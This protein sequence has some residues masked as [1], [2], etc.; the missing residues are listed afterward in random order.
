MKYFEGGSHLAWYNNRHRNLIKL[1]VFRREF[2]FQLDIFASLFTNA[3]WC[4]WTDRKKIFHNFRKVKHLSGLHLQRNHFNFELA[5][6]TTS[7]NG[8]FVWKKQNNMKTRKSLLK[9][10][11]QTISEIFLTAFEAVSIYWIIVEV[12]VLLYKQFSGVCRILIL[13]N[14]KSTP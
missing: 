6:L 10:L 5:P 3:V 13:R 14:Q 9:N 1:S 11:H 12:T 4:F 8:T 7:L 2:H